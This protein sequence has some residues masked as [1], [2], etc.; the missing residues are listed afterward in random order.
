[1]NLLLVDDERLA[2]ESLKKAVFEILPHAN[3]TSFQKASQ[4]I[5]FA[6]TTQVDIA[7]IDIDMPIM[8]GLEMARALQK[9]NP[10]VNVIFVTGFAEYALDAFDL[11]ASAYLTKPVTPEAIAK[12]MQQLRHP[13]EQMRVRL[14]CFGNFEI[15]C[16]NAPVHFTLA[17]TKELLAYLVDRQGSECRKN[18]IISALFEDDLNVEYYKKLRKDLIDTLTALGLEDLILVSRGGLALNKEIVQC[19]YYD[20]LAGDRSVP[21]L[22]YMT[23]YS[24]GEQTFAA[25]LNQ[26][27]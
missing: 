13:V 7:F 16:D 24:F 20:Y 1:M 3:S 4:A 19:D 25:L 18:E 6:E 22:E 26:E 9:L 14:H 12:A 27:K 5:A 11:C 23:Q 8:N 21:P 17:R 15:Y 2:L 10:Q